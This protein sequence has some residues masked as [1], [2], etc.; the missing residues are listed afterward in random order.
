MFG[1]S[2]QYNPGSTV[3]ELARAGQFPNKQ[4]SYATDLSLAAAA[5]ILGYTIRLIATPGAVGNPYHHTLSAS[6]GSGNV[7]TSLPDGLAN[8]LSA[9]F[10]HKPNPL[11]VPRK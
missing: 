3:D 8:A 1:F 11:P 7:L 9:T 10:L 2:V 5:A 6:D 4:I